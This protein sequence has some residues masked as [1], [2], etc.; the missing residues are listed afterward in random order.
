MGIGGTVVT[1]GTDEFITGVA[2]MIA[3]KFCVVTDATQPPVDVFPVLHEER[4]PAKQTT[5][6]ATEA[7]TTFLKSMRPPRMNNRPRTSPMSAESGHAICLGRNTGSAA[8]L[9]I[10]ITALKVVLEATG[11]VGQ[12][13]MRP[14]GATTHK[15]LYVTVDGPSTSKLA[16][17]LGDGALFEI[18]KDGPFVTIS[19]KPVKATD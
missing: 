11:M 13:I 9:G 14:A 1:V 18:V 15:M 7:Y 4:R 5:A 2:V 8:Q 6:I 3:W 19:A 16:I 12:V 17:V 10:E